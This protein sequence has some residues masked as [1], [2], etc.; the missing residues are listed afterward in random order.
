MALSFIKYLLTTMNLEKTHQLLVKMK[1]TCVIFSLKTVLQI[2]LYLTS[3]RIKHHARKN[4][5]RGRVVDQ[6]D[7]QIIVASPS[8]KNMRISIIII[9]S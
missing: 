7:D 8:S 5:L 3:R 2:K 4:F 6:R 1:N 9:K